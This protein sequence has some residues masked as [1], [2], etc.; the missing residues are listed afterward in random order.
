MV[1]QI[2]GGLRSALENVVARVFAAASKECGSMS[3]TGH[4][5]SFF[6][7]L[8]VDILLTDISSHSIAEAIHLMQ[9]QNHLSQVH[10]SGTFKL[11]FA[12]HLTLTEREHWNV[13]GLLQFCLYCNWWGKINAPVL[14]IFAGLEKVSC[15]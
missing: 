6:A 4:T 11:M 12:L 1:P 3:L 14:D 13:L 2:P 8:A 5:T 10:C 7:V 9:P 15:F